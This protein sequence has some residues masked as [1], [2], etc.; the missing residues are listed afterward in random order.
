ME[1][2]GQ[3]DS[4]SAAEVNFPTVGEVDV[5]RSSIRGNVRDHLW[6]NGDFA[7]FERPEPG[8]F[9]NLHSSFSKTQL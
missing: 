3:F 1:H 6:V 2:L 4:V 7:I 8:F 9:V 5:Y